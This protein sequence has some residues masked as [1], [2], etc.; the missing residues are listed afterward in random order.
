MNA[1]PEKLTDD[2]ALTAAPLAAIIVTSFADGGSQYSCESVLLCV[3]RLPETD[4]N[5]S[6]DLLRT[7]IAE[8]LKAPDYIR[9]LFSGHPLALMAPLAR[10]RSIL[11]EA[12]PEEVDSFTSSLIQLA[13]CAATVRDQS[14]DK[15][16]TRAEATTMELLSVLLTSPDE[17]ARNEITTIISLL[18]GGQA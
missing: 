3:E 4:C 9:N 14:D 15:Q 12:H 5:N 18:T 10:V 16:L 13:E 6:S 17:K 1:K 2:Q 7:K 11:E 8:L